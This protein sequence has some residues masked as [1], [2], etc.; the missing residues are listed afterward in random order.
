MLITIHNHKK[1]WTLPRLGQ[2]FSSKVSDS[3][4][5]ICKKVT[6]IYNV[7]MIIKVVSWF[8]SRCMSNNVS[9]NGVKTFFAVNKPKISQN[10]NKL[11]H[12]ASWARVGN[13]WWP[14][15]SHCLWKHS[16]FQLH[17]NVR[18]VINK[19]LCAVLSVR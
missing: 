3:F 17:P 2:C 16:R 8:L 13:T 11:K 6:F 9:N 18:L 7:S 19:Y 15:R 1:S 10:G 14:Q 12:V 5:N 4:I